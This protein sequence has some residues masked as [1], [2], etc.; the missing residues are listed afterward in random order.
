ENAEALGLDDSVLQATQITMLPN[1]EA[2]VI[3]N[4]GGD[5]ALLKLDAATGSVLAT[6]TRPRD[7]QG[8]AIASVRQLH[9]GIASK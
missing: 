8:Q 7:D 1:G 6:Y 4:R 3:R 5:P 2:V 9:F